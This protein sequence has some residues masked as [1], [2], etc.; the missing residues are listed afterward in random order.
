MFEKFMELFT[1]L[2]VAVE[3]LASG[4]TGQRAM[5]EHSCSCSGNCSGTVSDDCVG[6]KPA[7]PAPS[8]KPTPS[9]PLGSTVD[10]VIARAAWDPRETEPMSRYVD[11]KKDA[12]VAVAKS[13][14]IEYTAKD[15]GRKLHEMI[16]ERTADLDSP[17]DDVADFG[18]DDVEDF[19]TDGVSEH[20]PAEA[21][22]KPKAKEEPK[23]ADLPFMGGTAEEKVSLDD[24]RDAMLTFANRESPEKLFE[25]M[26]DLSGGATHLDDVAEEHYAAIYKAVKG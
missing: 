3:T 5:P 21:T 15:I 24:L 16:L 25:I 20:A 11:D 26:Q 22:P 17:Q 18:A 9:A 2:V 19:M 14:G 8:E 1:R 13:M 10:E 4:A 7:E 6:G 12:L 23:Q